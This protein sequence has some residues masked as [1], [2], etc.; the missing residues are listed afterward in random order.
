MGTKRIFIGAGLGAI[1]GILDMIPML[2]QGLTWDANLSAFSMWT[3]TGIL[4]SSVGFKM[5]PILKGISIAFLVL[6][7]SAILIAWKEPFSLVPI[8]TMTLILG[9]TLGVA[10]DKLGAPIINDKR[11]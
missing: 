8:S 1:A 10:I 3:I 6:L 5:N 9:G 7:P 4:I 2:I 11:N